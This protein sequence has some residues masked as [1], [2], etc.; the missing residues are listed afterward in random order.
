[1][2]APVLSSLLRINRQR[3]R[4][5]RQTALTPH[6]YVGVMHLIVLYA[7]RHPGAS[8]EEIVSFYAVDKASVA[9]D[10]RRLEDLGHIRREIDPANRRQYRLFLTAPGEE[11]LAVIDRAHQDFQRTLAANFSSGDW[12]LLAGLLQRLE[13][14]AC[15]PCPPPCAGEL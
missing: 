14:N 8:Q 2:T 15:R 9:R 10:A 6:G 12:E 3:I 13:E 5:L 11:M 7:G 1:M 4:T